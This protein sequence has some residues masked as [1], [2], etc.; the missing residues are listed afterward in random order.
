V[1]GA[2]L[3]TCLGLRAG[4]LGDDESRVEVHHYHTVVL[5]QTRQDRIRDVARAGGDGE[6]ARVAGD[7][8]RLRDAEHVVHR[9]G[10]DVRD[11]DEH[12]EPVH[13][14]DDPLAEG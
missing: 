6:G 4:G 7:D 12:A 5:C 1:L 3:A 9:L 13:L 8:R 10:R 2:E 11:V 14:A